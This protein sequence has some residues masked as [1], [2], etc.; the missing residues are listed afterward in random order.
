MGI[1]IDKV[2]FREILLR[3]KGFLYELYKNNKLQN[4]KKISGADEFH[5][6]TVIKIL[7]LILNNEIPLLEDNYEKVK[8]AR[9][10]PLLK[11]NFK[12]HK[13]FLSI[14]EGPRERKVSVLQ[15]LSPIFC[16]LL[17][18]LFEE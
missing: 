12:T 18:A 11:K 15:Q 10:V 16:F 8:K 17:S 5:L 1:A 6:N 4:R 7:H 14:V 9:K 13:D 3:D 2:Y